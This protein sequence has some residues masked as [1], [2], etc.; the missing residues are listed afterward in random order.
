MLTSKGG[1]GADLFPFMFYPRNV[2]DFLGDVIPGLLS[3][4]SHKMR[5]KAK[6]R[7]A[8]FEELVERGLDEE[9]AWEAARESEKLGVRTLD[10]YV[11]AVLL[12]QT[13]MAKVLL[14]ACEDPMRAALLGARLCKHM[15]EALPIEQKELG[16]AAESH[17]DIAIEL[18]EL[19]QNEEDAACMLL[20][21]ARHWERNVLELAVHSEMKKF[22]AHR[23]CQNL[24]DRFLYGDVDTSYELDE[25]AASQSGSTLQLPKRFERSPFPIGDTVLIIAHAM[26]PIVMRPK[27]G[28][29]AHPL[30]LRI[31]PHARGDV[32]FL[33]FYNIP[34]VKQTL[35]KLMYHAYCLVF[36]IVVM[37]EKF[38]P[39]L[40]S[41]FRVFFF[42]FSCE[43]GL[44]VWTLALVLDE[45]NQWYANPNTFEVDLWNAYDYVSLSLSTLA[46]TAKLLILPVLPQR[47]LEV[48]LMP[49]FL[50]ADGGGPG[51]WDGNATVTDA[52]TL[53]DGGGE[54]S[55]VATIRARCG[56][57]CV[58]AAA[59]PRTSTAAW[60]PATT[61]A[62][63][64]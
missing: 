33:H 25:V 28:D 60:P 37:G 2:W 5:S 58:A 15:A 14:T 20:S 32:S 62:R 38:M 49:R 46:L 6:K 11:W 63:S 34:Y 42:G 17:E 30:A 21:P 45:W 16:E 44:Y 54:P 7:Q 18:L 23:H 26:C 55:A 13:E 48:D 36:S 8:K 52:W 39:G 43:L 40:R 27:R 56:A 3:F 35:R 4:W 22:T 12:G 41:F 31:A 10:L 59:A 64:R 24:I 19:C 9:D 47:Y 61:R 53:A 51:G 29:E 1:G 50:V 57:C